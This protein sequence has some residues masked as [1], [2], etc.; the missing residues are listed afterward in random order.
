MRFVKSIFLIF[1]SIVIT[2]QAFCQDVSISVKVSPPEFSVFSDPGESTQAG[3]ITS[4]AISSPLHSLPYYY[5]LTGATLGS[6]APGYRKLYKDGNILTT[7]IPVIIAT[8][9]IADKD[10]EIGNLN[11]LGSIV[12]AGS[13]V[14]DT[15]SNLNFYVHVTV[16]PS[17]AD[18]VYTN[19]FSFS[20]YLYS[21]L[22]GSGTL[23]APT[24]GSLTFSITVTIN[25]GS[26]SLSLNPTSISFNKG[27]PVTPLTPLADLKEKATINITATKGYVLTVSS[28]NSGLLKLSE[29]DTIPYILKVEGSTIDLSLGAEVLIAESASAGIASYAL[30]LALTPIGD[31]KPGNYSDILTFIAMVH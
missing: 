19:T 28:S 9:P 6:A 5:L 15:P 11:L 10:S 31:K 2:L 13:M 26:V 12:L 21:T 27:N 20:L 23:T 18:G 30:E 16:P 1:F 7:P 25:Q 14:D 4:T 3:V 17:I 8:S 22:A 29:T 24:K